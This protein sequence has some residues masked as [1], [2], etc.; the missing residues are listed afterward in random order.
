MK[1]KKNY[2]KVYNTADNANK[3]NKNANTYYTFTNF[4]CF[5]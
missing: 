3:S 4:I 5:V 2:I 1:V